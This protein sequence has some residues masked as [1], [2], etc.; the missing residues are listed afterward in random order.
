MVS[1]S[2]TSL[3]VEDPARSANFYQ[4]VFDL[5]EVSEL[6]SKWFRGLWIGPT[7]L[8]FSHPEAYELLGLDDPGR[9]ARDVRTF[10]TMEADSDDQVDHLTQKATSLGAALLSRPARTYYGAWQSVLLDADGHAF[11]IDHLPLGS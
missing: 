11:R 3:V 6:T 4:E 2:F 8:G 5:L 10:L 7:V 9:Q 1:L